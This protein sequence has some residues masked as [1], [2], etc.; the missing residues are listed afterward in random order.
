[1]S[2]ISASSL[3]VSM[4]RTPGPSSTIT[5]L[6]I[7]SV[8][9]RV[10]CLVLAIELCFESIEVTMYSFV[11]KTCFCILELARDRHA[12]DLQFGTN[13][14]HWK[15]F[16]AG[17]ENNYCHNLLLQTSTISNLRDRGDR[18]L[19]NI[20]IIQTSNEMIVNLLK[21]NASLNSQLAAWSIPWKDGGCLQ[22]FVV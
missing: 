12:R 18:F 3:A 17:Q 20:K 13:S 2:N 6:V 19:F 9:S 4:P 16:F 5:T 21:T 22:I 14:A 15:E 7:K 1:M 11:T 8:G 10:P